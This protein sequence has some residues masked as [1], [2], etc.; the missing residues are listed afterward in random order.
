MKW[1]VALFF[2]GLF[3]ALGTVF[4]LLSFCTDYWLLAW[5]TTD[6]PLRE[7]AER[8]LTFYHEGF[9]WRCSFEGKEDED[10]LLKFWFTNQPLS[11]N[12][13]QAYLSP[14]PVSEQTHNATTYETAISK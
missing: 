6:C 10:I 14:F 7:N 12:C 13:V 8:N 5:E 3:A 1:S 4:I 11:K 9:F 2:A